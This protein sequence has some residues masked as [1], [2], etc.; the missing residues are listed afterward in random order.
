MTKRR[1][2]PA[3]AEK[4]MGNADELFVALARD[5]SLAKLPPKL[6]PE[7]VPNPLSGKCERGQS[8]SPRLV[9][10]QVLPEVAERLGIPAK[11][12]ERHWLAHREGAL[13]RIV[14]DITARLRRRDQEREEQIR[15]LAQKMDRALRRGDAVEVLALAYEIQR[16]RQ[17]IGEVFRN[18][19]T[20]TR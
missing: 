5:R 12:L 1:G 3:E 8:R 13:E 6:G 16:I 17:G 15:F 2:R 19:E 18:K 20:R 7:G 10:K 11:T 4:A 14:G 9:H